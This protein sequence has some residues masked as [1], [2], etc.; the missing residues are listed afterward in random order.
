MKVATERGTNN[1]FAIKTY[2]KIK[3]LDPQKKTNLE[4]EIKIL[5]NLAHNN[6]VKLFKTVESVR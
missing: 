5:N 4:R 2:D 3:L 1:K 6:I